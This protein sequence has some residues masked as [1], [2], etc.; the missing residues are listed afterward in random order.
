MNNLDIL[1]NNNKKWQWREDYIPLS[2]VVRY[3]AGEQ[4]RL[5]PHH[6]AS[7]YTINI[8]LNRV[9][10]DYEGGGCRFIRYNCSVTETRKGWSFIH[11]G[12]LTHYHEGLRV[13]KGTRYI[14]VSFV[15]L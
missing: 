3:R 6:D 15:D 13:T 4:D 1:Q 5:M 7:I 12:R 2:F 8:A 9:C 14:L 11:P 10:V